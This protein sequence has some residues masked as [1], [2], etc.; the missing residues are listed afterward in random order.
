MKQSNEEFVR[1]L[2]EGTYGYVLLV[3]YTN[4]DGSSFLAAVK[5]SYAAEYDS[6]QKE[7]QIL[8]ELRGCPRIVKCFGDSLEQGLSSDGNKVHKLLL[9]YASEGSLNAFMENHTDRKL[10]E[11]MIKDFTRMVLEGLV[12]IHDHGFV[13]CDLKSANLLVFRCNDSYELKIS[14]F[15]NALEVGQ[16]PD[17]WETDF[18]YVGTPIYMPPESFRDGVAFRDASRKEQLQPLSDGESQEKP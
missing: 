7:L 3:K 4:P 11:S 16:V 14:D 6:L 10:P 12:S 8:R 5:H 15:G 18:P 1:F 2:G 17:Y 13:H 9:E